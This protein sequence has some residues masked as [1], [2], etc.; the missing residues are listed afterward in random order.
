MTAAAAGAP[1]S[2][3]WRSLCP[4][5]RD[6]FAVSASNSYPARSSRPRGPRSGADG[7]HVQRIQ[8]S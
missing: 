1:G 7:G 6:P 8:P 2:C 3:P 4:R 5:L